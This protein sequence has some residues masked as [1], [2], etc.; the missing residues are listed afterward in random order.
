LNITGLFECFGDFS[1]LVT[2]LTSAVVIATSFFLVA[3][4]LSFIYGL[5][6]IANFAHGSFYMIGAYLT[7]SVMSWFNNFWIALVIASLGLGLV[8]IVVERFLLRRIYGAEHT[9]QFLLTFG[10]LLV[11][12]DVVRFIWGFN[13][14]SIQTPEIFQSPPIFFLGSPIPIYYIFIIITGIL[15][16]VGLWFVLFHTKLGKVVNAAASDSEMVECLGINVR[17]AYTIIF[18][19]GALLAGFGG[20]LAAPIRS[21]APGM[22]FAVTIDCFI[23]MVIGGIGSLGGAL[24]ASLLVG[25][26]RSFG[27]ILVPDFELFF[28]FFLVIAVLMFRPWGLFGHPEE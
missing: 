26:L 6:R 24:T 16:A 9:Y 17:L 4:G 22:G 21:A 27:I 20:A 8:G 19:L 18:A 14:K 10:L 2:Q 25:L 5:L 28:V 1:C 3:S 15:V 12:D 13:P 23:V 11:F 7:F